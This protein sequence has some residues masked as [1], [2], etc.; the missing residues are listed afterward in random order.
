MWGGGEGRAG[1][2]GS[3][4]CIPLSFPPTHQPPPHPPLPSPS[5]L[6]PPIIHPLCRSTN[7]FLR[8]QARLMTP[9]MVTIILAV[10]GLELGGATPGEQCWALLDK[11][12]GV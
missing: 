9:V 1:G 12:L 5:F 10:A 3:S 8:V 11:Q 4:T 7:I 6:P 2:A